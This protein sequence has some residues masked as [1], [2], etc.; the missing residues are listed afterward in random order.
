MQNYKPLFT[1]DLYNCFKDPVGQLGLQDEEA[2]LDAE[3]EQGVVRC[4][5]STSSS[6]NRLLPLILVRFVNLLLF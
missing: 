1:N 3:D 5:L 6:S 4:E 2:E